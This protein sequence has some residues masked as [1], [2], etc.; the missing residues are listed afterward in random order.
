MESLKMYLPKDTQTRMSSREIAELTGKSHKHVLRDIREQF[1]ATGINGFR[2]GPGSKSGLSEYA[3]AQGQLRPEY[4][5]DYEQTMILLTGY[6][7]PLRAKVIKRWQELENAKP[8]ISYPESLRL[9]A[10][11]VE[12]ETKYKQQ[13]IEQ[14]SAVNFYEAVTDSKKAI[15]MGE[16]A[17]VIDKGVGRNELFKILR[18]K[19]IL[20][21]NNEPYQRYIDIGW[22]RVIEQKF[23]LSN[24]DTSINIK[25]LVYQKGIEGIVNLFEDI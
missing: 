20:R 25:T 3:D 10:D 23:Q 6:S 2:S 8:V 24:G 11:A 4:L 17:K 16:V 7:I 9:L 19:N 21:Y 13:L 22:F 1:E 15:S 5:I 18:N 12:R 14:K